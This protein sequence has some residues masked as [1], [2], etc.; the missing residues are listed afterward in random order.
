MTNASD[1]DQTFLDLLREFNIKVD[2]FPRNAW[3][4]SSNIYVGIG[5]TSY[6]SFTKAQAI[7][8]VHGYIAGRMHDGGPK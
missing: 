5:D 2:G 3:V 7:S 1:D 6:G 8:F 4:K